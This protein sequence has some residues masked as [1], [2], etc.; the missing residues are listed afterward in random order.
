MHDSQW[1]NTQYSTR[2]ASTTS[3]IYDVTIP[4]VILQSEA[5]LHSWRYYSWRNSTRIGH[6]KKSTTTTTILQWTTSDT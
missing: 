4:S 2:A 1:H 5:C 3:G 6:K